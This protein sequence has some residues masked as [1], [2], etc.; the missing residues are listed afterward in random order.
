MGQVHVGPAQGLGQA[1]KEDILGEPQ[2]PGEEGHLR[3][4]CAILHGHTPSLKALVEPR[5]VGQS[6]PLEY[7]L[8]RFE[9]HPRSGYPNKG[10]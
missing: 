1:L 3:L 6:C 5:R 4:L 9:C 2:L 8:Y 10:S 7:L